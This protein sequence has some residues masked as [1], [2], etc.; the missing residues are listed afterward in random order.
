MIRRED[1][2]ADM[3]THT[4]ASLHAHSTLNENLTYAE[5]AGMKYIA[6]TDH[7]FHHGDDVTKRHEVYRIKFME[8]NVNPHSDVKV[9]TSAEFNILQDLEYRDKLSGL[10]WRPIGLHQSFVPNIKEM[11]YDDLYAAFLQASEWNTAFNHIE[12]ELDELRYGKFDGLIP[13]A[14]AF[15]EKVVLLAKEKN[16]FLE[17]N[18]H[19]LEPGKQYL[20]ALRYWLAIAAENGNRFVLGTD[21][22]F[23]R[24][25]GQFDKVVAVLNEFGIDKSRVLNCNEEEVRGYLM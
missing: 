10:K 13:E 15:L 18:E 21:A 8:F 11:S 24:E 19:S 3:H 7:Y 9:L 5:Q 17:I 25:V 6:C 23:C 16:I 14:E 22:H 1:I 20:P 2:I 12:R 4:V